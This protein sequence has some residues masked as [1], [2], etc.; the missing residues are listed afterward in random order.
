MVRA[1]GLTGDASM[2]LPC[3]NGDSIVSDWKK[4]CHCGNR[5]VGNVG[6]ALEVET[7]SIGLAKMFFQ[8][9]CNLLQKKNEF[10]GQPNMTAEVSGSPRPYFSMSW[11]EGT[12]LGYPL[13]SPHRC[14]LPTSLRPHVLYPVISDPKGRTEGV[15]RSPFHPCFK[16]NTLSGKLCIGDSL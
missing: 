12:G 15:Y 4:W 11:G 2:L 3:W 8:V 5:T 16:T 10:F 7:G 14:G 13:N 9:I 6:S 1:G